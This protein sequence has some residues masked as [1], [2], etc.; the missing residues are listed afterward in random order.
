M[1]V[2]WNLHILAPSQHFQIEYFYLYSQ[3]TFN[4]HVVSRNSPVTFGFSARHVI[5]LP[6]SSV[7]GTKL[8]SER[9][10]V[11]TVS[12]CKQKTQKSNIERMNLQQ[13]AKIKSNAKW[14]IFIEKIQNDLQLSSC[15]RIY[16][17]ERWLHVSKALQGEIYL[18]LPVKYKQHNDGSNWKR[19]WECV[20]KDS[21]ASHWILNIMNNEW[22]FVG[23]FIICLADAIHEVFRILYL[24]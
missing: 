20:K 8:N 3:T 16:A 17:C 14:K 1:F 2:R 4:F 19:V 21:D 7:D 10:V 5:D 23:A 11:F 6:S 22:C 24:E 15:L 9:L 18:K 13:K 12:S